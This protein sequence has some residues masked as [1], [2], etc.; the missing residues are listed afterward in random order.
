[1]IFPGQGS[2]SVG[3]L[4]ELAA[5][6]STVANT[7]VEAGEALGFD[8]WTLVAE[9]P[10]EQLDRTAYTQPAML[11][12]GIA[13]W[14]VWC[15]SG[16]PQPQF[17]SGHSLGEY[18]ALVA[19]EALDFADALK[20]T[21]F[22]GRAMQDAVPVGEGG[23]AA[24]LGIDDA[25]VESACLEAAQGKVVEAVNFNAPGQV[26]IAGEIGAVQRAIEACRV[27]GAK[28]AVM[29]PMSVPAHSSLMQP[30]A[31]RMH[32]RLQGTVIAAPKMRYFSGVDGQ[33]HPDPESIRA[34]LARQPAQPVL[35][36]T[37]VRALL[38]AGVTR[39]LECGPGR[40]LTPMIRRVEKRA[41]VAYLTIDDPATL[42]AALAS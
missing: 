11:A 23:I 27:R 28:R 33:E 42:A 29:L 1:M 18:T 14:R 24:I 39:F 9:G 34:C 36:T 20:L 19:A 8:L 30:A 41:D 16:G 35:W 26:V 40:V 32:E 37:V 21:Q 10:R 31:E 25:A 4:A 12:A 6:S 22:R 17:V 15:E 7:F 5:K 2:Q 13:A 38:A 3:M